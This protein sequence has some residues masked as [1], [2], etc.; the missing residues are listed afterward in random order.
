[1]RV[2][3]ASVSIGDVDD[4]S[5]AEAV[6]VT[7]SVRSPIAWRSWTSTSS[8]VWPGSVRMSTSSSTRSGI[9]LIFEPPCTMFGEKVVWVQAWN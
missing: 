8:A 5:K 2:P 3:R 9:V 7:S 6:N 4:A 1:M